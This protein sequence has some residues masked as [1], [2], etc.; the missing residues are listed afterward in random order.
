MSPDS[1]REAIFGRPSSGYLWCLHCERGYPHGTYR[2]IGELQMCP[3]EN[4]D[5]DAVL[6]AW[7]WA[8]LMENHPEYPEIPVENTR[9]PLY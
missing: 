1:E 8:T 5:G 2:Q 4:C 7:D 9:Y 6:D 3:Y